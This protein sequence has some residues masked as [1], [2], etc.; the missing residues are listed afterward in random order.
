MKI[1]TKFMS[2]VLAV[3]IAGCSTGGSNS[4]IRPPLMDDNSFTNFVPIVIT[5]EMVMTNSFI[6]ITNSP[7]SGINQ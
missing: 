1:H 4:G 3:F 7:N 5:N 6:I 2:L